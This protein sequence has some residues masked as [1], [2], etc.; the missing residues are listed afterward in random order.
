VPTNQK[1]TIKLLSRS[2]IKYTAEADG[3]P[4]AAWQVFL[5]HGASYA[6]VAGPKADGMR[7]WRKWTIFGAGPGGVSTGVT[8]PATWAAAYWNFR[9]QRLCTGY[10]NLVIPKFDIFERL[11]LDAALV[12]KLREVGAGGE[13]KSATTGG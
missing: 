12:R 13:A 4:P 2:S 10:E 1:V 9:W 5:H 3:V 7:V 8:G 6:L 11:K